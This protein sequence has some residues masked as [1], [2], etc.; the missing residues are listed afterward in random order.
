MAGMQ[1]DVHSDAGLFYQCQPW[2]LF[3]G[4]MLEQVAYYK[5]VLWPQNEKLSIHKEGTI[6]ASM[7]AKLPPSL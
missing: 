6:L 4:R 7:K 2:D 3:V 1:V 5:H